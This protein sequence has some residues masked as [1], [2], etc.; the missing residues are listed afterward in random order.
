MLPTYAARRHYTRVHV[1]VGDQRVTMNFLTFLWPF[2]VVAACIYVHVLLV[3]GIEDLATA[4]GVSTTTLAV[5]TACFLGNVF[6]LCFRSWRHVI[7]DFLHQPPVLGPV[8]GFVMLPMMLGAQWKVWRRR[9]EAVKSRHRRVAAATAKYA[10]YLKALKL[11]PTR[12]LSA[13]ASDL[14]T[15]LRAGDCTSLE[16]T[17]FFLRRIEVENFLLNAVVYLRADEALRDAK[18]RDA[19]LLR[20]RSNGF[21]PL[22][23]FFG[24]PTVI[25]EC[26]EF[27]GAPYSAGIYGRR[28]E[29]GQTHATSMHRLEQL[30]GFVVMGSTNT[31][32]ACMWFEVRNTIADNMLAVFV[33]LLQSWTKRTPCA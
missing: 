27:P 1:L 29:K 5:A 17:A 24:V 2:F 8:L 3:V 31:S 7:V 22:S 16:L 6:L 20:Q 28:N 18:E 11:S 30:G 32:E 9:T 10:P 13:S 33:V 23:P 15:H 19:E 14:G 26:M 21:E 4:A 25:K 12:I